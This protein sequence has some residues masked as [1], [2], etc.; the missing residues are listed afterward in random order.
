MPLRVPTGRESI[1]TRF[2]GRAIAAEAEQEANELARPI[3]VLAG[4]ITKSIGDIGDALAESVERQQKLNDGNAKTEYKIAVNEAMAAVRRDLT[5]RDLSNPDRAEAA[6]QSIDSALDGI[7]RRRVSPGASAWMDQYRDLSKS[8]AMIELDNA[9]FTAGIVSSEESLSK[10]KAQYGARAIDNPAMAKELITELTFDFKD[11][12][13]LPERVLKTNIESGAFD[14]MTA[15]IKQLILNNEFDDA[16]KLLHDDITTDIFTTPQRTSL[17]RS[18]Q[19]G[20]E[21]ELRAAAAAAKAQKLSIEDAERFQSVLSGEPGASMS[22]KHDRVAGNEFYNNF[23]APGMPTDP[24]EY[25]KAAA[26]ITRKFT[27]IPDAIAAQISGPIRTPDA[28]TSAV[29]EASLLYGAIIDGNPTAADDIPNSE[30]KVMDNVL[31]LMDPSIGMSSHAAVTFTRKAHEQAAGERAERER[32]YRVLISATG[33]GRADDTNREFL[34]AARDEVGP[35]VGPDFLG[36][37][38][39]VSIPSAMY[40]AFEKLV[41][42]HYLLYNNLEGARNWALRQTRT[43]WSATSVEDTRRWM[44]DSPEMVYGPS[45]GLSS[46][47][48]RKDYVSMMGESIT[49]YNRNPERFHIELDKRTIGSADGTGFFIFEIDELGTIQQ[50]FGP[51]G[52]LHWRPKAIEKQQPDAVGTDINPAESTPASVK[53]ENLKRLEIM[54]LRQEQADAE[55]IRD[56]E[57][58]NSAVWQPM[59]GKF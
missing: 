32:A 19:S 2:S 50:R 21:A 54:K 57:L 56:F 44:T 45:L 34:E 4:S 42:D 22:R 26:M 31:A 3:G 8:K 13:G 30:S 25:S 40:G 38:T 18:I 10:L 20:K 37:G 5:G 53:D 7:G 17:E 14:I 11:F 48:L 33:D 16:S 59:F 36:W 12:D 47:T 28:P 9:I 6:R 43:R 27:F 15:S 58:M 55:A 24:E 35:W 49:G 52:P 41:R 39:D 1:P 51:D 23:I 46:E 29:A